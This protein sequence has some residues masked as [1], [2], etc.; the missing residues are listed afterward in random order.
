MSGLASMGPETVVIESV[1]QVDWACL[2]SHIDS[3]LIWAPLLY[4]AFST[5][6]ALTPTK[7]DDKALERAVNVVMKYKDVALR[8]ISLVFRKR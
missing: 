6:V 3:P 5:V 1:C 7:E 8:I 4:S 2:W